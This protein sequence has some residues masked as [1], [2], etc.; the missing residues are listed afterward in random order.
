[1]TNQDEERAEIINQE[2]EGVEMTEEIL[3]ETVQAET[4]P[5]G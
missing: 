4:E 5:P 1:M 2:E 3:E